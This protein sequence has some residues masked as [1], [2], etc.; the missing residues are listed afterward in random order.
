[1]FQH[2]GWLVIRQDDAD[3]TGEGGDHDKI[4]YNPL[5]C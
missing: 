4:V 5:D 3:R 1:M 2:S